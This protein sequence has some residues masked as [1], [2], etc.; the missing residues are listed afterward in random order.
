MASLLSLVQTRSNTVNFFMRRPGPELWKTLTSVSKSG[1]KKGRRNTR[2]PVRPLQRFYRIGSTLSYYQKVAKTVVDSVK[3]TT[4]QT[5]QRVRLTDEND[6]TIQ[7]QPGT[8]PLESNLLEYY[9]MLADKGDT[10]AQLGLGQIYLAGG[11]GL[12]Q[13]FELAFRYLL[14]AAESGSSDALMY[15]GK[16]YL[17]GTSFTP[18][19]Y[20]KAFEYLTKAADKS[21][22][23]A[24]AVLGAMY[25]KGR[26]VRKN[27]E[28]A[29][30][31][32]TLAAD[33]KNADGQ[34]YLAELNY[35][36]T[37]SRRD[38]AVKNAMRL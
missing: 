17:D 19:D 28:K 8:A 32:L 35:R 36:K 23:G 34:M 25:M 31:L 20:Q 1:Q 2:Q 12:N 7:M 18:K 24:Q 6:P 3:F 16:M 13:N 30:K 33:K 22:P 15:L 5:I 38:P 27:I 29:M 4:G 9:K 10:S 11:R 21:S 14:S 37:P 26:G